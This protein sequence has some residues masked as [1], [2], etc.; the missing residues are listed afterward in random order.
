MREKTQSTRTRN[1]NR[2]G[3]PVI[4]QAPCDLKIATLLNLIEN[5][6][7]RLDGDPVL[8]CQVRDTLGFIQLSV[9]QIFWGLEFHQHRQTSH[10]RRDRVATRVGARSGNQGHV[11]ILCRVRFPG[12]Y[13]RGD[14][15]PRNSVRFR[16]RDGRRHILQNRARQSPADTKRPAH[17]PALTKTV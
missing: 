4:R 7:A 10:R 17:V 5:R 1:P 8:A 12:S 9:D 16:G 3:I 15:A 14:S 2:I 13:M 11:C 6:V